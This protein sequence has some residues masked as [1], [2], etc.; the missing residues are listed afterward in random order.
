METVKETSNIERL[1]QLS[2]SELKKLATKKG[3]KKNLKVSLK[4]VVPRQLRI[5]MILY[6]TALIYQFQDR[7]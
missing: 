7:A 3:I 2:Y 6:E 4:F 5:L 1:R